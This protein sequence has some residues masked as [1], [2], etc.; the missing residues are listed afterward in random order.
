MTTTASRDSPRSSTNNSGRARPERLEWRA[1]KSP[2]RDRIMRDS[3]RNS[4]SSLLHFL[5]VFVLVLA[6]LTPSMR[7]QVSAPGDLEEGLVRAAYAKVA[8]DYLATE[9]M[10][11]VGRD[12]LARLEAGD[13]DAARRQFHIEVLSIRTGPIVEILDRPYG[14]FVTRPHGDVPRIS[15]GTIRRDGNDYLGVM[16]QWGHGQ[17]ATGDWGDLKIRD[18][19]SRPGDLSIRKYTAYEVEVSFEGKSRRYRALAVYNDPYGSVANPSV[20]FLDNFVGGQLLGSLLTDKRAHLRQ[21]LKAYRSSAAADASLG[22]SL[23]V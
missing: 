14:E 17:F 1:P 11:D 4:K 3:K 20:E 5:L 8:I 12:R 21:P 16:A 13:Q 18:V 22:D 23:G 7:G 15:Q 6:C 9:G 10:T 2:V 19:L